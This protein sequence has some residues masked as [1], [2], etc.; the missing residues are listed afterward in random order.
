[1]K[2]KDGESK[3]QERENRKVSK[4]EEEH[5]IGFLSSSNY[6]RIVVAIADVPFTVSVCTHYKAKLK[7]VVA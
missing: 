7:L 4:D 5:G 3:R 6:S 2:S 1:M